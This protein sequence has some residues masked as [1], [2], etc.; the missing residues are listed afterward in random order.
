M[1]KLRSAVIG[2]G[3]MGAFSTGEIKKY[4]PKCWLPY[5]HIESLKKIKSVTIDA[6]CDTNSSLLK[7]TAN[8]Y[9]IKNTYNNYKK[10]FDNHKIDLLCIA[11]RTKDRSK[12]IQAGIQSGVKSFHLEK[13]LCN[14]MKELK[15]IESQVS[16]NNICL[17]YGT[18]RRYLNI[19]Q[20][21]KNLADSGKFGKLLQIQVNNGE[22][23]LLW[24]HPHSV[25][26][27]LFF[28]GKRKLKAIQSKL[29]NI[30]LMNKNTIESDPIIEQSM[31]YF[32][33]GLVGS[34]SK[35]PSWNVVLG[36]EKGVIT[37][38][39]NGRQLVT[40]YSV[41]KSPYFNRIKKYFDSYNA[42]QGTYSAISELITNLNNKNYQK[43]Q[44]IF[45]G[46]KVLFGFV[47]SHLNNGKMIDIDRVSKKITVLGKTGKLYA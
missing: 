20:K 37:V 41:N 13:P 30:L 6:I 31:M 34:I 33:D 38:E 14:S 9:K 21:A 15:E 19:Y 1:E 35:I 24:S 44:F 4:G 42:P 32:D 5:T 40:K 27:I 26:M 28:S 17:S 12:I 25:D 8:K 16:K 18:L 22:G 10:L 2:C 29:S 47:E 7:K 11:T 39:S 3:R 36:C 23:P 43:H 45:L 46:Q